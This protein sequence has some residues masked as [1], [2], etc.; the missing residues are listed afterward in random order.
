MPHQI[1]L[2]VRLKEQ[3]SVGFASP[4]I[5]VPLPPS[6][7]LCSLLLS[8]HASCSTKKIQNRASQ[9]QSGQSRLRP[10]LFIYFYSLILA[11]WRLYKVG[12]IG[13]RVVID[14]RWNGCTSVVSLWTGKG[15]KTKEKREERRR[16]GEETA[17]TKSWSTKKTEV[18]RKRNHVYRAK[19]KVI[20]L[21]FLSS[22]PL[23]YLFISDTPGHFAVCLPFCR[24]SASTFSVNLPHIFFLLWIKQQRNTQSISTL[25]HKRR[26]FHWCEWQRNNN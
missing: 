16:K 2:E 3:H 15:T 19:V 18:K 11:R 7:P 26:L 21:Y 14:F 17:D 13:L 23:F 22:L 8:F 25:K 1:S 10:Q 5:Q 20:R 6:L 24:R 12:F 9:K 4:N